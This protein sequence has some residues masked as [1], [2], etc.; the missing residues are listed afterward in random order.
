MD[1]CVC[2]ITVFM[3]VCESTYVYMHSVYEYCRMLYD[4]CICIF[5]YTGLVPLSVFDG[6]NIR[7]SFALLEDIFKEQFDQHNVDA[8]TVG[9]EVKGYCE[10]YFEPCLPSFPVSTTAELFAYIKKL[11]YHN[12]LSVEI[13]MRLASFSR[14]R[15]L[16]SLIEEYKKTFFDKKLFEL[17]LGRSI[18][19]IQIT[20]EEDDTY[21]IKS[22]RSNTVLKEDVT[23]N[24]LKDFTIRY[25]E[26]ILYLDAGI[27][28]P[29]CVVK[30]SICIYWLIPSCLAD[31][32]YH[33]ACLNIE[34]FS[35]LK[36]LS[37]T[38]GKFHIKPVEGSAASK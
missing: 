29:Q 15:Y 24:E 19:Q 36:I 1:L 6:K 26:Q 28:L 20:S 3:C 31:Y 5:C 34:L 13:L 35:Q 27:A 32:A 25:A 16:S 12:F 14:I 38:I 33:S 30:G 8:A 11:P 23:I 10:Q 21:I 2:D 4:P 37:I 9:A 18:R 7:E 17:F 22:R